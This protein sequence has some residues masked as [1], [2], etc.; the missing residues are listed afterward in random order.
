MEIYL[1]RSTAH[2]PMLIMP[3]TELGSEK[4]HG[5]FFKSLVYITQHWFGPSSLNPGTVKAGGN[6]LAYS[7]IPSGLCYQRF[8][9]VYIDNLWTFF[10]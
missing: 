10:L 6:H 3:N 8:R 2:F 1:P 5:G 7:V 9:H 4:Y